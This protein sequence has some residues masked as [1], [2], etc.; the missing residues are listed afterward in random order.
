M[1]TTKAW[2]FWRDFIW[3]KRLIYFTGA[4]TVLVT[5]LMQVVVVRS[6]GW[7]LDFFTGKPVVLLPRFWPRQETFLSLFLI[8]LFGR[9]FLTVGRFGWRITLA[10]QTHVAAAHMRRLL[11]KHT[12]F[13]PKTALDRIYTKGHM[14]NVASSDVG[15][16][17]LLFGFTLV[18]AVDLTCLGFLTLMAMLMINAKLALFCVSTLLFIPFVVRRLSHLEGAQYH[19]TQEILS[20]LDDLAAQMISSVRLQ[21]LTRTGSYWARYVLGVGEDYRRERLKTLGFSL[22]YIPAMGSATLLSYFVLFVVGTYYVISG[23]VSVGDFIAMQGLV[24]LI[25]DPFMEMGFIVSEWKRGLS[26]LERI[27][28]VYEA[29]KEQYLLP[30][31]SSSDATAHLAEASVFSVHNLTFQY[32]EGLDPVFKNLNFELKEQGRLGLIGPIATGKTTLLNIL[33]GLERNFQGQVLFRGRPFSEYEHLELRRQIGHVSQRPFLFASTIRENLKLDRDMSDEEI[34]HYLKMA[35]LLEDVH[36][37]PQQ[38]DTS[39]GEWGINLSGGQKQR[40]TLARALARRPSVLLF[41]DCLSA[42]DTVTEEKILRNIDHEMKDVTLV[43]AAHRP[44]TLKYCD[45]IFEMGARQ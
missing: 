32:S 37:F 18:A 12:V 14:I 38:L 28:E 33:M 5:N 24:S 23:R 30:K 39:L 21:R 3:Q 45:R 1:L 20:R 7:V 29:P 17:Q 35:E 10:R 42:V 22:S 4:F 8:F 9:I 44:S 25:Q 19:I 15:Q 26:S 2:K 27:L 6:L 31:E 41:D 13:F 36:K 43:W 16:G 40:L 34:W 11:W